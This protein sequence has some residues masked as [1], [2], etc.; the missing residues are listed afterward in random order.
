MSLEEFFTAEW[1]SFLSYWEENEV[2]K[3]CQVFHSTVCRRLATI[4]AISSEV[5]M[6]L[7][8][9]LT[10]K[11]RPLVSGMR[12]KRGIEALSGAPLHCL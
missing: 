12:R 6:T 5:Q 1:R 9:T 8:E 2:S 3:L 11:S 7:E 4:L 10:A